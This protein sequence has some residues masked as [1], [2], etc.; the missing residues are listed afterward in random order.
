MCRLP[1]R[2]SSA[3]RLGIATLAWIVAARAGY[4]QG[5]P[6]GSMPDTTGAPRRMV[7]TVTVLPPIRVDEGRVTPPSRSTATQVTMT[8]GAIVRFLPAN[9]GEALVAAPGVD[10]VRTGAWSS[11]IAVRGLAGERVLLLVDGVRLNTGRGHGAQSSLVPIERLESIELQPGAASAAYGSD[12]LGGVV[13]L[14]T[15]RP[16]FADRAGLAFTTIARGTA[17]GDE[18]SGAAR[19]RWRSRDLG[20]ELGGTWSR[21]GALS[22]PDGLLPNSGDHEQDVVGRLAARRGAASV[23]LEQAHHAARDIGIPA[24]ATASGSSA[25]YPLEG[26]DA[27]RLELGWQS[28]PDWR[29]GVLAS[30]QHYRTHFRETSVGYDSLRGR[31]I[32]T[33]TVEAHDRIGTRERGVVPELRLGG[34]AHTLTLGGEYR[35]ETTGGPRDETSTT[36]N[37]SGVVTGGSTR[38]G[39]GLPAARREVWSARL[40]AGA[41]RW[42]LRAEGGVRFDRYASHADSIEVRDDPGTF[43]PPLDVTDQRW[44]AEGGVS[45]RI[46]AIEPY[47]HV[48][49]GFRSPSLEERFYDD[50]IHGG[51]RL[52]GNRDLRAERSLSYELGVRGE[53][54]LGSMRLSAYRANVED[55]I[56]VRYLDLVFGV[57]RFQYEN[58]R[59]ARLDGIELGGRIKHGAASLGVT[60][61]A[62]RGRDLDSGETLTDIGAARV[63]LDVSV[64]LP[65]VVP[66]GMAGLRARWTDAVTLDRPASEGEALAI[67]RPSFWTFAAETGITAWGSRVTVAVRNLLDARYREP[68]GFIDEP[69]RTVTLMVQRGFEMPLGGGGTP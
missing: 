58:V 44:S 4:A 1:L 10:L 20:A 65:R 46:G 49:S 43:H 24:F 62:P 22:T 25:T 52:F 5:L 60:A 51:M 63:A 9:A 33:T 38:E 45:R 54:D 48:A 26:R 21:L 39:A 34:A 37:M 56:S 47:A 59:R 69:G 11:Q 67:T 28:R 32:A 7:D 40:G 68:L 2:P 17:P 14:V 31:R 16:L 19:V 57:P 27:T 42:G 50:D 6:D 36:Q 18:A 23:D 13:D 61:T 29:L 30:D 8:R 55:L 53:S 35:L 12:A 3:L 41:T 15:H 64:P 66:Q